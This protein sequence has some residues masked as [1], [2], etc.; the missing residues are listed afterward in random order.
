MSRDK[1]KSPA[2]IAS[3]L[4]E[5]FTSSAH[6]SVGSYNPRDIKQQNNALKFKM[7]EVSCTVTIGSALHDKLYPSRLE[8]QLG[9]SAS[10]SRPFALGVIRSKTGKVSEKSHELYQEFMNRVGQYV[11]EYAQRA[12]SV[13]GK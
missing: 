5:Y 8:V 6:I 13:N 7:G 12:A 4:R 11:S 10:E 9:E 2:Y 1:H 3:L